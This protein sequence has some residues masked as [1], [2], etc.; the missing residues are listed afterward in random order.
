MDKL[1]VASVQQRMALP[2]SLD[3]HRQDVE[4]FFRLA[5][6]KR[7]RLIVFPEL[8]GVMLAPPLMGGVQM[9]LLKRSDWARRRQASLWERVSGSLARATSRLLGV[10]FRRLL[11]GMLEMAPES[12]WQAYMEFYGGLARE[13]DMTV[14]APSAYLP[15]P[16]DGVIR[17]I[18]G[19]FGP[20]GEL[21]GYQAKGMLH[22][23]D[24]GLALAG[25][26]WRVIQTDVGRLGIMLGSD[27]LYPEV[28]R[29]LAYQQAEILVAQGAA[30]EVALYEKLRS[31][32]LARMQENQLFG[33]ASFLVGPNPVGR[34]P[35]RPF[36]GRSAILAP[37]E[38]TPRQSGLLV[39]MTNYRSESVLTALWDFPALEELW[40]T[41]DTPLRRL[42]LEQAGRLLGELYQKLQQLPSPQ[43][44]LAVDQLT[45][46]GP[47][48]DLP[49]M[50]ENDPVAE[51][52]GAQHALDELPVLASVTSRWPLGQEGEEAD[53][54]DSTL[55]GGEAVPEEF[56]AA[57]AN[58]PQEATPGIH[59]DETQEMDA[60]LRPDRPGNPEA[61]SQTLEEGPETGAE[62]KT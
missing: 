27:V 38:L 44:M 55:N 13:F 37:Q 17:N 12:L 22:P 5:A 24:E 18:T 51:V 32:I 8:A 36:I 45:A 15:D 57:A 1:V 21:L 40:E 61:G 41:S 47:S 42:P 6:N 26:E 29:L 34:P 56:L 39:E 11:A 31:G 48:D 20:S 62:E 60:L 50:P 54:L 2:R 53:A 25:S 49:E 30:T 35:R 14:V 19:V 58:P 28:G 16:L 7:A 52:V 23:E 33:V 59:E 4:R 43:E 3:E 10:D 9:G 46:A